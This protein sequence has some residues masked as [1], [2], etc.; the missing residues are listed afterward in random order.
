MKQIIES[1]KYYNGTF[2]K[3]QLQQII[4]RKDEAIPFLIEIVK[5]VVNHPESFST[6]D[7]TTRS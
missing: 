2:P 1:I 4:E 7:T 3:K 5:E 6:A